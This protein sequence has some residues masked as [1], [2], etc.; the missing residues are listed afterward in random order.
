MLSVTLQE[1]LRIEG[2][3]PAVTD[4]E[5]C[6]PASDAVRI[7]L[8]VPRAIERVREVDAAPVATDLDHL[9]TAGERSRRIAGMRRPPGDAADVDGAD[10]L[11]RKRVAHVVL[12]HL[13]GTPARR[14]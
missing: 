10:E 12:A 8:I 11:R 5:L 9:R 6:H 7:K 4:V 3:R 14:V 2:D 1:E 13:S